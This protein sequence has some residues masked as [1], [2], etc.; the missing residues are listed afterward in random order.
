RIDLDHDRAGGPVDHVDADMAPQTGQRRGDASGE[1]LEIA[2]PR[3]GAG[4]GAAAVDE[5]ATLAAHILDVAGQ[6]PARAVLHQCREAERRAWHELLH[7]EIRA[8]MLR[9]PAR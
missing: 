8:R 7:D 1:R 3:L 2:T 9:L 4:D 6:Q 5:G